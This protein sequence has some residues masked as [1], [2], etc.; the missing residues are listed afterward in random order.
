MLDIVFALVL[1]ALLLIVMW[2]WGVK[3]DREFKRRWPPI[4]DN[5]FVAKCSPSTDRKRALKVRGIIAEQLGIPREHIHPEQSFV[6]DLD[7]C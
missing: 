4:S 1:V 6:D 7:C 2:V 3:R 5:E